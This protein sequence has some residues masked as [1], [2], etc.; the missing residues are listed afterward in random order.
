MLSFRTAT[1]KAGRQGGGGEPELLP[2]AEKLGFDIHQI[3]WT[4]RENAGL[5]ASLVKNTEK[6]AEELMSGSAGLE[7]LTA[8]ARSLEESARSVSALCSARLEDAGRSEDLMDE[9]KKVLH[10]IAADVM[11]F[12]TSAARLKEMSHEITGF[13]AEVVDI[14]NQTNLLALNAAIESAR[15]GLAGRGFSVVA[16]EVRKLADRSVHSSQMIAKTAE[17]I[18]TGINKV[19]SQAEKSARELGS[20]QGTAGEVKSALANIVTA[21]QEITGLNQELS[22]SMAQQAGTTE[23]LADVFSNLNGGMQEITGLVRNQERVHAYLASL[24]GVL[25]ENV[26]SLQKQAAA[27]RG[28]KELVFG[29]NPALSPENIRKMY[30]PVISA[31]CAVTGYR[32]AVLITADYNALADSLIDGVVD[33]GW[34]SPL[35]YVNASERGGVIPLATPV[36]NGSPSYKGYIVTR[37]SGAASLAALKGKRMAFVDPKSASGYAYPRILLRRAGVDPDRDLGETVFLGTHSRVIDAVLA[38][39]VA[40]GATYSEA[41][42]DAAA[43]GLRVADLVYLAETEPIPKD[44]L[45]GRPG[46]N[47][48][49]VDKLK[50]N[51]LKLSQLEEGRRAMADSPIDGFI[52]ATDANY[53]IVREVVREGG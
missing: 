7:E 15:A 5:A 12:A 49:L 22:G 30:L 33:V 13:V 44:C 18:T 27:F 48:G 50:R 34:F 19:A 21:F 53:D 9:A 26:Y 25:S 8:V 6:N 24:S 14:A 2:L 38:G 36:V 28:A 1:A 35:A 45:A 43:R 17:E 51:L 10:S 16:Q 39:T 46:L 4:V 3:N 20:V 40:A 31:L 11:E 52:A 37:A 29:I 47:P 41:I 23:Y 42:D 32:P